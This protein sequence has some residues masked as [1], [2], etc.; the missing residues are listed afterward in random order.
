[1]APPFQYHGFVLSWTPGDP[2]GN[3]V[4]GPFDDPS[5]DM[6]DL[7]MTK[8]GTTNYQMQATRIVEDLPTNRCR[9]ISNKFTPL[10]RR[11]SGTL[12][13]TFPPAASQAKWRLPSRLQRNAGCDIFCVP[14]FTYDVQRSTNLSPGGRIRLDDHLETNMPNTGEFQFGDNLAIWDFNPTPPGIVCIRHKPTSHS[15]QSPEFRQFRKFFRLLVCA[16]KVRF[17]DTCNNYWQWVARQRPRFL[18]L[19]SQL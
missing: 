11:Q 18:R 7:N 14:N 8:L 6:L 2:S 16:R 10:I 13:I 15:V 4:A 19:L 9:I 5:Q 3:S 17:R 1:M 12:G